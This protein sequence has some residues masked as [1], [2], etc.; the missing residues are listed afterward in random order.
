MATDQHQEGRTRAGGAYLIPM[1]VVHILEDVHDQDV[2]IVYVVRIRV[3]HYFCLRPGAW[4]CRDTRLL[5]AA[6]PMKVWEIIEFLPR[7]GCIP[8]YFCRKIQVA[9]SKAGA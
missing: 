5:G 7:A 4:V 8:L 2:H 9:F 3:C 1:E 6:L